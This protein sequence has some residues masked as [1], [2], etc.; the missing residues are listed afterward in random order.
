MKYMLR[1]LRRA[2]PA[3]LNGTALLWIDLNTED[4]ARV[5]AALPT[6]RAL[7]KHADKIVIVSHRGRPNSARPDKKL[8]LGR[9]ARVLAKLFKTPVRFVSSTNLG[10]IQKAVEKAPKKSILLLENIRFFKG[11]IPGNKAFARKL[12]TLG[13]YFINDAF[14]VTHHASASMSLLPRLLPSFAGYDLEKQIEALGKIMKK[15]RKPFVVVVGGAKTEDKVGVLEAYSRKADTILVGGAS[16]NTLLHLAGYD[17]GDSVR[18][19]DPRHLK[20]FRTLLK[21]KKILMPVDGKI[22]GRKVLDIGPRTEKLFAKAIV[23]ARTILWAGPLGLIEKAPYNKGS[24]AIARAIAKNHKAFS[25]TGGGETI[26]FLKKYKLDGKFS[27]IST[28]GGAMIE[29]LAGNKLPGIEALK[30]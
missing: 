18:E 26:A 20:T 5:M 14:A 6:V 17:M 4:N 1:T 8:S 10:A 3:A 22:Q 9:N 27:F 25:V 19:R 30:R 2:R 29:F 15:P 13:D 16:G 11:E 24:L 21:N 28:G 7:R 12:A 23:S